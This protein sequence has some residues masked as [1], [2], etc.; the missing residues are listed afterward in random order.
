MVVVGMRSD[1]FQRCGMAATEK[2]TSSIVVATMAFWS[3]RFS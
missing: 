2:I 3:H 1:P